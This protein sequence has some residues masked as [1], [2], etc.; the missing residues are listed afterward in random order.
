MFEN[1]GKKMQ[2]LIR[3]MK[4]RG[5]LTES[6]VNEI[7]REVRVALLE[8]DVNFKVVKDFIAAIKGKAVGTEVLSS[9]TPDQQVV[10]I[11]HD[12]LVE[13]LGAQT[14]P[15]RYAPKP[16]TVLLL[17]G[18]QGSGKTT[19]AAKLAVFYKKQGRNPLLVACDL[20]RP[21][22]VKQLQVL[23]EQS[24]TPV[25]AKPGESDPVAVAQEAVEWAPK[26]G[27]DIVILDTAGRLHIDDELMD[28]VRRVKAVTK[29]VETLLVLDAMTGQDAV[30]V[31]DEFNKGLEVD[32]F[33]M[34]KLDGDTRG[35]AAISIRAVV[36]KPIKLCG[37]SEKIDGLE[38][39]HP[40]RMAGRILGMG[41]VLT[42]IETVLGSIDQDVMSESVKRLQDGGNF[43]MNEFLV[44]LKQIQKLPMKR[45]LSMIPGMPSLPEGMD[46]DPKNFTR[47]EAI[48]LSMTPL[49][50]TRPDIINGSRRRRISKGSGT[51][52]QEVNALLAQF[53]QMKQMFK[54]MNFMQKDAK[55]LKKQ[56]GRKMPRFPFGK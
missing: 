26:N 56:L 4:D 30:R 27:C 3:R 51:T 50:R 42:S 5:K 7:L 22:A 21:A 37:I 2:D 33:I 53:N 10:K 17:C 28:Q 43:T 55:Q 23:G 1:L 36:G 11:V 35:G 14:E 29:P 40:D 6:D 34:S 41:D 46:I 31:A 48:I 45:L 47:I 16:P 8:A 18:L 54:K 44:Y 15:L 13:M 39:F 19:T 32:G 52:V 9:L 38:V 49:E 20:Q 12:Q 25:F 24:K